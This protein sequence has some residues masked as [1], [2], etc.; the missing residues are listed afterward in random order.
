M[1]NLK[2]SENQGL[3]DIA[4][5]KSGSIID[6]FDLA[7]KNGL[8]VT[9]NLEPGQSLRLPVVDD[10]DISGYFKRRNIVP[11][12]AL[13]QTDYEYARTFKEEFPL[14]FA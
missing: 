12:T 10:A 2:V 1:E 13:R 9:D 4:I 8:S 7:V 6:V 3:F 11:D 14:E 5:Q